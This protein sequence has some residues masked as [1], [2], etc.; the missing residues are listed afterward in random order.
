MI[1]GKFVKDK[2][3]EAK[4]KWYKASFVN[5]ELSNVTERQRKAFFATEGHM[6]SDEEVALWVKSIP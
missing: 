2:T 1:D 3:P 5:C 6:G 4:A